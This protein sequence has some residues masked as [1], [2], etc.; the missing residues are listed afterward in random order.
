[1]K[2]SGTALLLVINLT[3]LSAFAH[4]QQVADAAGAPGGFASASSL[5]SEPA[6]TRPNP[7]ARLHAYVF[8]AFGPY[9]ILGAAAVAGVSQAMNTPPE[10]KQGA[11]GYGKRFGSDFGIAAIST[12]TR[13]AMAAALKEDTLYYRCECRGVLPRLSHAV[14][15]T[16]TARHGLDGHRAFSISAVAAPYAGTLAG[17]SAWY[18]AN[19]GTR[20]ALRM[21]NYNL[22]GNVGENILI[23]FFYSGPHSLLSHMHP[24][25]SH[26]P[27]DPGQK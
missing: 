10:W 9:P 12:T 16:F 4:A 21:G 24:G 19:Y 25:N 20:Y 15:S 1:M 13:Y 6:Y 5:S 23:E 22:L 7:A 26:P 27:Q 17:V 3:L 11:A 2:M 14:V 8:D 18:P